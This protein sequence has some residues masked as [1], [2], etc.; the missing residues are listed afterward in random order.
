MVHDEERSG[1]MATRMVRIIAMRDIRADPSQCLC[2]AA[3][4]HARAI[5]QS[6]PGVADFDHSIRLFAWFPLLDLP[7]LPI[8]ESIH[9]GRFSDTNP[10]E[11]ENV[12]LWNRFDDLKMG[13]FVGATLRTAGSAIRL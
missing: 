3:C 5:K 9:E 8:Q 6:E 13:G 7:D 1:V 10:P 2:P 12:G 11:D 4:F